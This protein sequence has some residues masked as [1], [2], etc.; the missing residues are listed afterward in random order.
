MALARKNRLSKKD[1]RKYFRSGK[2]V[3]GTAYSL[4][5]G[6]LEGLDTKVAVVVPTK[7]VSTATERNRIRRVLYSVL[8]TLIPSVRKP[9]FLI[10]IIHSKPSVVDVA[11]YKEDIAAILKKSA[12]I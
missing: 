1:F 3:R 11:H 9:S 12:I 6:R 2:R 4:Q 5:Y 7:V 8:E 10:V